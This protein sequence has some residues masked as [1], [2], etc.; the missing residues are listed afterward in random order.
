V[1]EFGNLS[2]LI[3]LLLPPQ[4]YVE[5]K[6]S[7]LPEIPISDDLRDQLDKSYL[8]FIVNLYL[9]AQKD[10][11]K[12]PFDKD[13]WFID[14]ITYNLRHC[15]PNLMHQEY[16]QILQRIINQFKEK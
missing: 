14:E 6:K 12:L 2:D 11:Q 3:K 15:Y 8:D 1:F 13:R 4:Q 10:G 9:V 5:P 16:E 7:L